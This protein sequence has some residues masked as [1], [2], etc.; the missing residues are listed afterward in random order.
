MSVKQRGG[1]WQISVTH[2]G[3]R[4]R[5][6]LKGTEEQAQELEM[7]VLLS[8]RRHGCWP[9][10]GTKSVSPK[11]AKG[12]GTFE[13]AIKLIKLG[14]WGSSIA[15]ADTIERCKEVAEFLGASTLLDD[16]TTEDVGR[17][18]KHLREDKSN[19]PATI[20][21]KLS[22]F[23]GMYKQCIEAK[24]P[25]AKAIPKFTRPKGL[26]KRNRALTRLEEEKAL[27]FFAD[28]EDIDMQDMI[29]LGVEQ[30]LR[31]GEIA[32]LRVRSFINIERTDM[33]GQVWPT[34]TIR[35]PTS[36]QHEGLKTETSAVPLPLTKRAQAVALRRCAAVGFKPNARIFSSKLHHDE[37]DKRWNKMREAM[38]LLD[39]KGFTF[40]CTRHATATRLVEMGVN[41]LDIQK[42]MRH[43][44]LST[45]EGYVV[46]DHSRLGPL[47]QAID[48]GYFT[49]QRFARPGSAPTASNVP[50]D[51]SHVADLL[52]T[53]GTSN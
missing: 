42:F 17:W 15:G 22:A 16:V 49:P 7:E 24:P 35:K 29:V 18:V 51:V 30:G 36:G 25:L 6:Q 43:A 45:T 28:R 52:D 40:H 20:R 32:A 4:V 19:G 5:T 2:K 23:T 37:I 13:D 10:P 50:D 26:K 47:V 48:D 41:I 38:G 46:S 39:D 34:E 11:H 31:L 9:A 12:R 21:R 1:S 53:L 3:N 33:R 44:H 27:R 14:P 8:L